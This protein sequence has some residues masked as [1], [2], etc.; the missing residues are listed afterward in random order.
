MTKRSYEII[1]IQPR[2]CVKV[3]GPRLAFSS[4]YEVGTEVWSPRL[5]SVSVFWCEGAEPKAS[6]RAYVGL[7]KVPPLKASHNASCKHIASCTVHLALACC[8]MHFALQP[9][10]CIHASMQPCKFACMQTMQVVLRRRLPVVGLASTCNHRSG[11]C[12]DDGKVPD[13][14]SRLDL[15]SERLGFCWGEDTRLSQCGE[16]RRTRGSDC[17]QSLA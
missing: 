3:W 2:V 6:L 14:K 10:F 9:A 11:P 13:G 17:C 16:T 12:T 5:A 4:L 8:I 15:A 1:L 7:I